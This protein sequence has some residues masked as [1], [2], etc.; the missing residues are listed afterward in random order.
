M[1]NLLL[2]PKT[3]FLA[4]SAVS[5]P[6]HALLILGKQGSGKKHLANNLASQIM[7]IE[8]ERLVNFPYAQVIEP[9]GNSI[10]IEQI[11]SLQ[12]F[13]KLR[14]PT[15][16]DKDINRVVIIN[17]A[18]RMRAEAQNTLLKTLEEPPKSTL[19]IL[20]SSNP[21]IL[22]STITSRVQNIEVLPVP[23]DLARLYFTEVSDTDFDKAYAI[24]N[25]HAG[26]LVSLLNEENHPVL[27]NINKAK[28]LLSQT[29]S[30]RLATVDELAKD[31]QHLSEVLEAILK[32]SHAGLFASGKKNDQ[33]SVSKWLN[34]QQMTLQAQKHLELNV[35]PKLLL[36]NLFINI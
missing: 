19:I 7:G 15:K 32:V 18:E 30:D 10:S 1:N 5:K 35:Q 11:R 31:K 6:P 3:L 22:L 16:S 23:K 13:L 33:K 20:T 14:V 8:P 28:E 17:D 24:S 27:E 25:G 4:E 36:D 9:D 26:L 12:Q 34:T 21:Q 2:H 29:I